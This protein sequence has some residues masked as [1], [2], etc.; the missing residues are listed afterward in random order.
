[1]TAR[2]GWIFVLVIAVLAVNAMVSYRAARTLQTNYEEVRHTYQVL[3]SIHRIESALTD[4]EA[5]QRGY[6]LTGKEDYLGRYQRSLADEEAAIARFAALTRDNPTQQRRIP[7][8]RT[9]VHRRLASLDHGIELRR[10]QNL[11]GA[12]DWVASGTG[13]SEMDALLQLLPRLEAEEN[14]LLGLRDVAA[15]KSARSLFLTI[16]LA[17]MLAATFVV[18]AWAFNQ[19]D[20]TARE[21]A[22]R[23][24]QESHD[25]LE[26]R[27]QERTAELATANQELSRSNRELQDFAFV[28][29]HDLQEPLRK[30]QAFGDLLRS[31]FAA[32]LGPEGTDFIDRMQNAARRMHSLIRDLL[33]YSR[34]ATTAEP[35]GPV[36]L[37]IV[38]REVLVDLQTRI[39]EGGGRVDVGD[40]PTIDADPVQI[41]Q[42][43]QN[44]VGNALKFRRP[45]VPPIVTVEAEIETGTDGSPVCRIRVA[46]NG[47]G[48]EQKYVDRIF[49]PFQR[50]HGGRQYEGTGMGLAVCRRIVERHGGEIMATSIPGEG[51]QFIVTLPA[52]H[53]RDAAPT[54][55]GEGDRHP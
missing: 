11:E 25:L 20:L 47:I 41:R 16:S 29:S 17:S 9:R 14:R 39:E 50:L 49:T 51:S 2:R 32:K 15:T 3:D 24:L 13:K 37:A 12:R 38:T 22:R 43:M 42:L 5:A 19:R 52:H 18:L 44:V 55:N 35:F 46:D 26:T 45:G 7:D 8:L 6:I 31:E 36:D 4:A 30:I 1:M 21:R 28:A 40:L 53:A 27:V 10:S 33:A 23:S 48:F 54:D 34:V